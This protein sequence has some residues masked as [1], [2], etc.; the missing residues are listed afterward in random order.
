MIATKSEADLQSQG[1][2]QLIYQAYQAAEL[3]RK[4]V[5]EW[6]LTATL[7][8]YL[9][10]VPAPASAEERKDDVEQVARE[11]DS[12]DSDTCIEE[13]NDMLEKHAAGVM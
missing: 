2:I 1:K 7:D 8:A 12:Q 10:K 6:M 11:I 9:K 13:L 4:E 5:S 3:C